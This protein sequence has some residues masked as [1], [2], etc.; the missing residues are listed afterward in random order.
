MDEDVP[1]RLNLSIH[2]EK[3]ASKFQKDDFRILVRD[4]ST[5]HNLCELYMREHR[6]ARMKVTVFACSYDYWTSKIFGDCREYKSSLLFGNF[7]PDYF[8]LDPDTPLKQF[9]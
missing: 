8:A 4:V 1:R 6:G 3:Y 7:V 9:N 2:I 5:H